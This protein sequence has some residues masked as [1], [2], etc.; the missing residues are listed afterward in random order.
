MLRHIFQAGGEAQQLQRLFSL[1]IEG[2]MSCCSSTETTGSLENSLGPR[3]FILLAT[4]KS[5]TWKAEVRQSK[6]QG[7]PVLSVAL[8]AAGEE[9]RADMESPSPSHIC[10][11]CC[12]ATASA[13]S[14]MLPLLFCARHFSIMVNSQNLT[15]QAFHNRT[16]HHIRWFIFVP[17]LVSDK[18]TV[19]KN[20]F[21][22]GSGSCCRQSF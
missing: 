12:W 22:R 21:G 10:S 9:E 1:D 13:L 18:G 16:C 11:C 17:L 8:P 7:C 5:L 14:S 2:L 20:R 3:Y 15:V 4:A 19:F 6:S